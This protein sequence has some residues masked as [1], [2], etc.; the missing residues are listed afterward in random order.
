MTTKT[1]VVRNTLNGEVEQVR[2]SFLSNAHLMRNYVVVDA[3]AKPLNPA[4]HKPVTADEFKSRGS[5]TKAE[6]NPEKDV[7]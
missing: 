2:P 7:A 3:D 1:V 5:K 4:L 6:P